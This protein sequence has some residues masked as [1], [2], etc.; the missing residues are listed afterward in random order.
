[1]IPLLTY[2]PLTS[3]PISLLLNIQ[4]SAQRAPP[5]RGCPE[6]PNGVPLSPCHLDAM[7]TLCFVSVT[8]LLRSRSSLVYLFLAAL[9]SAVPT[10]SK[11]LVR[12]DLAFLSAAMSPSG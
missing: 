7:T 4:V 1:M 9:L 8:V 3:L 10:G 5:Q 12:R 6:H 2:S 11:T